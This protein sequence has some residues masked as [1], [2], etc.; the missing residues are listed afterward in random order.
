MGPTSM[1]IYH[2]QSMLCTAAILGFINRGGAHTSNIIKL[3]ACSQPSRGVS[4][5][6]PPGNFFELRVSEMQCEAIFD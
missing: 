4:G 5:H 6:A 2:L 3:E 1:A